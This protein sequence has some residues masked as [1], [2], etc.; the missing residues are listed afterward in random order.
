M[1]RKGILLACGA[2]VA[3]GLVAVPAVEAAPLAPGGVFP[4][5]PEAGPVGVTIANTGPAV[6]AAADNSFTG[7][8]VSTVVQNDV[9]NPLG[10][11][12]FTYRLSNTDA[13]GTPTSLERL[14]VPGFAGFLTDVSVDSPPSGSVP[15]FATR[16]GLDGGDVMGFSYIFTPLVPGS[17]TALLVVQTNATAYQIDVASV[18][19]GSTASVTTFSPV[20]E[21]AALGLL[22]LSGV[23]LIRRR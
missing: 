16:S 17:I 23:A 2:V 10:G 1:S 20:P 21:P 4:P 8:L 18:I 15:N 3:A 9:T 13:D 6:F 14:T 22:A 11:L 19:N 12:T 7:T 5:A